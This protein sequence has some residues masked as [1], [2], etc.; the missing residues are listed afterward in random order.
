MSRILRDRLRFEAPRAVPE[1]PPRPVFEPSADEQAPT[2][3]EEAPEPTWWQLW[4]ADLEQAES[5]LLTAQ[6]QAQDV[7]SRALSEGEAEGYAAGY[8]EGLARGHEQGFASGYSEGHAEGHALAIAEAAAI[9]HTAT[10]VANAAQLDRNQLLESAQTA[11]VELA[12]A[13]AGKIVQAEI[14]ANPSLVR[15]A[16]QTALRAVGDSPTAVLHVNPEDLEVLQETWEDLKQR[17]GDGGLQLLPDP[18][19]ERGGCIVDTE[20]R[21]VDAQIDSKM[22]EISRQLL[23]LTESRP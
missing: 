1:P 16:V 12:T 21:T 22:E 19:I 3:V 10:Q 8:Q 9:I 7:R 4:S 17:F 2:V 11:M 5:F 13:I 14:T 6:A 15:Q 18:R 20:S 23:R